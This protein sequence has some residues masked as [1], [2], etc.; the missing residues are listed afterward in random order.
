MGAEG[1][2]ER[3]LQGRQLLAQAA[4]D[5]HRSRHHL[6]VGGSHHR[7]GLQLLAGQ[8]SPDHAG[9]GVGLASATSPPQRLDQ[10][11]MRQRSA[12]VGRRRQAEHHHRLAATQLAA[13]GGQR[14]RIERPQALRTRLASIRASP[15]SDLAR[16]VVWRSRS[17]WPP[18]D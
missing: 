12:A 3:G 11:R 2:G 13:K 10:L 14:C 8:R 6:P 4:D 7:R 16:A 9:A 5:R 1:A 17:R 18:A 15:R